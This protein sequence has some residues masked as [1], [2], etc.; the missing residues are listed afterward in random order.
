MVGE[1]LREITVSRNLYFSALDNINEKKPVV[2]V[3]SVTKP[4]EYHEVSKNDE[5]NTNRPLGKDRIM[6]TRNDRINHTSIMKKF[7]KSVSKSIR[8]RFVR[9]SPLEDGNVINIVEGTRK[10]KYC[11]TINK[12]PSTEEI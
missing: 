1:P 5:E 10:G 8:A 9:C 3:P 12:Q 4:N 2:Y 7:Y 6:H 11:S